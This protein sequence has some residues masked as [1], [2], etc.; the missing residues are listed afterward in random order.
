M[1][2]LCGYCAWDKLSCTSFLIGKLLQTELFTMWVWFTE[3]MCTKL[4]A[5][6]YYWGIRHKVIVSQSFVWYIT[7]SE[8][9][10][11]SVR[12]RYNFPTSP[13]HMCV[14]IHLHF[15]GTRKKQIIINQMS[16]KRPYASDRHDTATCC[17]QKNCREQTFQLKLSEVFVLS[18]SS[19]V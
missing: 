19:C 14:F 13:S 5:Y 18:A 12:M 6:H 17:L 2:F 1:K 9:H 8:L 3:C 4:S 10:N 15:H 7:Q 16:N 11:S